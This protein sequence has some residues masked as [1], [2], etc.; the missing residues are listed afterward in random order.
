MHNQKVH[1]QISRTHVCK[2][3]CISFN[4]KLKLKLHLNGHKT[5]LYYPCSLCENVYNHERGWNRHQMS[6]FSLESFKCKLC[7]KAFTRIDSLKR[8]QR[9]HTGERPYSCNIC[10]K[11][12]A[13]KRNLF[14][15]Q[16]SHIVPKPIN[17][18]W[19]EKPYG[20]KFCSKSF[21]F[22]SHLNYH[23]TSHTDERPFS[24]S[25]CKKVYKHR[26]SLNK[27]LKIHVKRS[28]EKFSNKDLNILE[29]NKEHESTKTIIENN[30]IHANPMAQELDSHYKP[31]LDDNVKTVDHQNISNYSEE[32]CQNN[33]LLSREKEE[34][35]SNLKNPYYI[36]QESYPNTDD[37]ETENTEG[38]SIHNIE[39]DVKTQLQLEQSQFRGL[40]H[41][42][43]LQDTN[44]RLKYACF[45]CEKSFSEIPHLKKHQKIHLKLKSKNTNKVPKIKE[46]ITSTVVRE[47]IHQGLNDPIPHIAVSN[48]IQYLLEN[49]EMRKQSLNTIGNLNDS[50]YPEDFYHNA[51]PLDNNGEINC[52]E[53]TFYIKEEL[54]WHS[55]SQ[56]LLNVK[57]VEELGQ[58]YE[59]ALANTS[60]T[61]ENFVTND[62]QPNQKNASCKIIE[63][64]KRIGT[65]VL[66][67]ENKCGVCYKVIMTFN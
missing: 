17:N 55:D 41:Y 46:E 65:K 30:S 2:F 42:Y 66:L 23:L 7:P 51:M 36:K 26:K 38:F 39:P 32:I 28:L 13:E 67:A 50:K 5:Q 12:Y 16:K 56:E 48:N 8:H 63:N 57:N 21:S 59:L 61:K 49:N 43:K 54:S 9:V 1:K 3:C 15:H 64:C 27:H 31:C 37:L 62:L 4:G 19:I 34:E 52:L 22:E 18:D 6:H 35:N 45:L 20:C 25:V 47:K 40:N 44:E 29:M 58:T 11:P 53:N 60:A 14:N 24:C 33:Q 10:G